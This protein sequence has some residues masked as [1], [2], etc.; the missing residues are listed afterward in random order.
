[1]ALGVLSMPAMAAKQKL[2]VASGWGG[3]FY[4]EIEKE[5][6][7][8][9]NAA[10]PDV[11]VELVV[12]PDYIGKLPA[13]ALAGEL[14]DVYPIWH[15]ARKSFID[16]GFI[17]DLTPF[18]KQD[19]YDLNEFLPPVKMAGT[20]KGSF[21]GFPWLGWDVW[22]VQ[23]SRTRFDEAG[24]EYPTSLLQRNA[25]NFDTMAAAAAKL[26]RRTGGNQL[27]QI[28]IYTARDHETI[29]GWVWGMGGEAFSAD[30][31]KTLI[32]HPE[33]VRG[34]EY[35]RQLVFEKD[36]MS[37]GVNETTLSWDS[38]MA[39]KWGM[40]VW[41]SSVLGSY[42]D[43]K[44]PLDYGQVPFPA[45]PASSMTTVGNVNTW[46]I[47]TTSKNP[48]LAW[49]YMK[50]LGSSQV[51]RYRLEMSAGLPVRV[52]DI[53]FGATKT[54]SNF[55]VQ[56]VQLFYQALGTQSRPYEMPA[57][58]EGLFELTNQLMP[59]WQGKESVKV[60][61]EKTAR[62]VNSILAAAQ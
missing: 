55:N 37:V 9:Y 21:W 1:M 33:A 44:L 42:K 27:E 8:R 35:A 4:D 45:G 39:G 29:F 36:V 58:E 10:H 16:Q 38:F 5:I 20:Y 22:S 54:V 25:W 12:F 52:S 3:Q 28:G 2:T 46:S 56:D 49:E 51:Y 13:M 59:M 34:L 23:F 40:N 15:R 61:V 48:A 18:I 19:R 62:V 30:G 43:W 32:D 24:L 41:W 14:P 50:Y 26:T 60:A 6:A 53:N 17:M 57:K 31:T 7:A 47:A 11:E